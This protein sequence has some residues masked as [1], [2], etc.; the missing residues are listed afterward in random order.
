[1]LGLL[2]W[3]KARGDDSWWELREVGDNDWVPRVKCKVDMDIS[4]KG[5]SVRKQERHWRER[6]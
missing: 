2:L 5:V 1:V 6:A 4:R 3:R